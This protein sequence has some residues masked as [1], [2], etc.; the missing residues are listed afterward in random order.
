M[1]P[2]VELEVKAQGLFRVFLRM[3]PALGTHEAFLIPRYMWELL[4]VP[5]SPCISF[6]NLFLPRLYGL[7]VVLTVVPCSQAAT[8]NMWAF[9]CFWQKLLGKVPQVQECSELTETKVNIVQVL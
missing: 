6:P 8:A 3:Y 2:E 7:F 5:N 9:K 4:K 1:E